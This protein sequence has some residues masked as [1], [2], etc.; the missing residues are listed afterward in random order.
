MSGAN[1]NMADNLLPVA[2]PDCG[3][4]QNTMDGG[5]NADGLPAGAVNCMVC[6]HKFSRQE[7]LQGL[8]TRRR[9]FAQLSGPS[10]DSSGDSSDDLGPH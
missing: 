10:D 2:C 5:F 9:S 3:E 4:C 1:D 7:Y 6:G 8:E